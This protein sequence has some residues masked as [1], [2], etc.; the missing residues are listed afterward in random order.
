M[1]AERERGEEV[2]F[3]QREAQETLRRVETCMEGIAQ[4]LNNQ[5]HSPDEVTSRRTKARFV[6][7]YPEIVKDA[8]QVIGILNQLRQFD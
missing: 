7:I 5:L 4:E 2:D 3:A 1:C 8:D 6:Q